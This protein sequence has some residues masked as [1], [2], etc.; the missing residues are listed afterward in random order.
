[1]DKRYGIVRW[2]TDDVIAAA[3]SNGITMTEEQAV[4]WWK[5]NE[6]SFIDLM[7]EHGNEVLSN[8]NFDVDN[9]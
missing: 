6:R 7:K 8:M 9:C 2:A 5:K 1:M 4:K 3:E